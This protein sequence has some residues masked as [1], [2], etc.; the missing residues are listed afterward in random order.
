MGGPLVIYFSST[1]FVL[2]GFWVVFGHRIWIDYCFRG[3]CHY[4]Y[5]WDRS[6]PADGSP[7]VRSSRTHDL[8]FS[9]CGKLRGFKIWDLSHF[10]FHSF[11]IFRIEFDR[12]CCRSTAVYSWTLCRPLLVDDHLGK[13]IL[14]TFTFIYRFL[15]FVELSCYCY[16]DIVIVA[17]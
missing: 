5:G 3:C 17:Y 4:V 13:T 8:E 2:V 15:F 9:F 14:H 12:L 10:C 1:G 11:G 6:S 7:I 16:W